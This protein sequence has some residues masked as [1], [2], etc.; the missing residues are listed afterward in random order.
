MKPTKRLSNLTEATRRGPGSRGMSLLWRVFASNALVLVVATTVLVVSPATVSFPVALTEAVVLALGLG[1]ML[2]LNLVLLRRALAPLERLRASMRSTDPLRPG[3]RAPVDD[4]VPELRGVTETFNEMVARLEAERRDSS[5]RA[6]A[7]Q[8]E[9]R[10]R[11]ARELHDEV[12]QKLTAVMLQLDSLAR[13]TGG[14]SVGEAREGVRESLEEVR[15]IARRLRPEAL[16]HLGLPAALAALT[17]S[18]RGAGGLSIERRVEPELP[19]LDPD[20]ELV[21]YRVAQEALTNVARH[22]ACSQARLVL[23]RVGEGVE[24]A[25]VDTGLGFDPDDRT[26][27]AGIRGMRERALLVGAR[28]EVESRPGAGTSVTLRCPAPG[29]AA[30]IQPGVGYPSAG[31]RSPAGRPTG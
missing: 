23:R 28:L 2:A 15:F 13:E 22:A 1:A 21:L 18:F 4:A 9:E 19:A 5:G 3:T 29:V 8:E 24:L 30:P 6:L 7:A 11:I 16:D 12:G 20:V 25:V 26:E 17:S 14:R 10:T 31:Q 27:G